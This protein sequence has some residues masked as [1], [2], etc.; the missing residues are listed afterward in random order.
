MNGVTTQLDTLGIISLK[1]EEV[2]EIIYFD[3]NKL[4]QSRHSWGTLLS[5]PRPPYEV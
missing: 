5:M 1:A 2:S 4:Q 3:N